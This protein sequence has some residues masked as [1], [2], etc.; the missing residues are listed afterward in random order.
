MMKYIKKVGIFKTAQTVLPVLVLL[1]S[2][3]RAHEIKVYRNLETEGTLIAFA[4]LNGVG[5]LVEKYKQLQIQT[6][7]VETDARCKLSNEYSDKVNYY[8]SYL[9]SLNV[10]CRFNET[11]NRIEFVQKFDVSPYDYSIAFLEN[12]EGI[13][14]YAINGRS[15]SEDVKAGYLKIRHYNTKTKEV[16]EMYLNSDVPGYSGGMD[17][18]R[19][20]FYLVSWW[21]KMNTIYKMNVRLIVDAALNNSSITFA[22]TQNEASSVTKFSRITLGIPGLS[23]TLIVTPTQYMVANSYKDSYQV[24]KVVTSTKYVFLQQPVFLDTDCVPISKAKTDNS[25]WVHCKDGGLSVKDYT[26]Q[27]PE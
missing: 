18:F 23:S 24:S 15:M 11:K 17:T 10:L 1:T 16:G 6:Y 7:R 9:M 3:A 8:K 4:P 20:S 5:G 13:L 22:Q 27:I 14:Y 21:N 19:G 26:P 12:R 25:F 2:V